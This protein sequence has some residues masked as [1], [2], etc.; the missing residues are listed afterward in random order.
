MI[1]FLTD[2]NF[3]KSAQSLD[4]KRLGK[5]RVEAKQILD[6]ILK[7]K[8]LSKKFNITISIPYYSWVRNVMKTYKTSNKILIKNGNKFELV[9]NSRKDEKIKMGWVYHP[10]IL[11]WINYEDALKSYINAHINEWISRGYK[12]NME[13]YKVDKI[14]KPEW[15]FDQEFIKRHQSVLMG[16]NSDYYSFNVE[17]GLK[18]IW[19]I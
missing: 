10:V 3:E 12:N 6:T 18:Y 1:T 19:P 11:M 15:C 2:T 13:K 8:F 4:N 14:K 17:L 7:L 5:Q 9:E 16:K